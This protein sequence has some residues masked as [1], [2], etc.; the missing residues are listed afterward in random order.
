MRVLTCWR[1]DT[2]PAEVSGRARTTADAP[3]ARRCRSGPARS[4]PAPGPSISASTMPTKRGHQAEAFAVI[5]SILEAENDTPERSAMDQVM[6]TRS[7][8]LTG[9]NWPEAPDLAG[10]LDGDHLTGPA[11]ADDEEVDLVDGDALGVESSA[12]WCRSRR[13]GSAGPAETKCTTLVSTGKRICCSFQSGRNFLP[14]L[15]RAAGNG[16]SGQH[17]GQAT[18]ACG[19]L[20]ASVAAVRWSLGEERRAPSTRSAGAR[21]AGTDLADASGGVQRS[22]RR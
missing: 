8:T 17:P 10:D 9:V 14:Y 18:A 1:S 6:A 12:A 11:V 4:R 21:R 20:G 2:V 15:G 13:L 5:A 7:V 22:P 3:A 19:G 16:E